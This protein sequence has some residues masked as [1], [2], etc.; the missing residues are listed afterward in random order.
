MVGVGFIT[1]HF[2]A[3]VSKQK[4]QLLFSQWN[5]CYISNIISPAAKLTTLADAF[6]SA[7]LKEKVREIELL[8]I[9]IWSCCKIPVKIHPA[10]SDLKLCIQGKNTIW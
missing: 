7:A 9:W 6:Q 1:T 2:S 10:L 5:D 3:S 4:H 8:L